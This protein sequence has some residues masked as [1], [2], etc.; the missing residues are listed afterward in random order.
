MGQRPEDVVGGGVTSLAREDRTDSWVTLAVR[1][2]AI[3]V[4]TYFYLVL[5]FRCDTYLLEGDWQ[6]LI[7]GAEWTW[8]VLLCDCP[9][10]FSLSI[11]LRNP[12]LSSFLQ[13]SGQYQRDNVPPSHQPGW[14][15]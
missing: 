5:L 2:Y 1:A 9:H 10:P 14:L 15:E 4:V 6:S 7:R 12:F 11:F 8:M 13:L 3:D